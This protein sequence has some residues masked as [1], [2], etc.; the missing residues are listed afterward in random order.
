MQMYLWNSNPPKILINSGTLAGNNYSLNDNAF[1]PGH[2]N[3]PVAPASLTN[4]LVLYQDANPDVT[5]ACEVPINAAALN[6]KIAVIRRGTCAFVIKVKNAQNAGAIGAIIVNNVPGGISMGG[7]DGTITIPAVSMSLEEGEELSA[8]MN[9]GTVNASISIQDGAYVNADG[10]FDNGIIAHEYGHGVSTRLVGGGAG[11]NSAEQPGEGWS[12][13]LW[14]MMQ[15]K[16]GDTRNDARGIGTFAVNEP[17][18]GGGIREYRYSTNMAVNPHTFASTNSMWYT[19]AGGI[20]N[21]NVHAV[22]SVWCV[23]LWDLAWNYIDRYGYDA[24]LYNGTG[25]NNKVMRL[26]IDAMK[27]TPANPSLIQCRNAIIQADVN[28]TNGQ[29]YC[30]I[31]ETFAR[32]G[33]GVN[34]TSG[35]NVGASGIQDQVED[36]TEPIP[37]STPATGSN[38]LLANEYFQNSDSFKIYPNPTNG[39]VNINI[40]NYVGELQIKVYDLNGRQVYNQN[41]SNFNTANTINLESLAT[42]IYVL[43]L[44]GENLNYSEKIILE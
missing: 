7:A 24:N 21:V 12:D 20:E 36:F 14:L 18:N 5:D 23:I 37:G 32:R 30:M 35:S 31:W 34:A 2:V 27:L 1:N 19:D 25:G 28:S 9:A 41:L 33:M 15:I 40:N 6:G 43:K 3:L 17:T 11:L 10:D 26:V 29:N 44:Q 42:G 8:S 13:W 22:G 16:P 38:C 4:D 39:L